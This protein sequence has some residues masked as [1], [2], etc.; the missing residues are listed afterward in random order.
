MYYCMILS[1]DAKVRKKKIFSAY[2]GLGV[3][4]LMQQNKKQ[5]NSWA[6]LLNCHHNNMLYWFLHW[7]NDLDVFWIQTNTFK[8]N[9]QVLRQNSKQV[10]SHV[11]CST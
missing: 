2:L 3:R 5:K 11:T 9:M 6:N 4:R 1:T 8:E 10:Y 7:H